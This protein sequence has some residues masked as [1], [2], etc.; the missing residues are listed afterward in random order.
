[1]A[2]AVEGE[3]ARVAVPGAKRPP[4]PRWRPYQIYVL[5]VLLLV[6]ASNYLDRA[7]VGILQQPIK[8]DLGLTDWQLGMISGPA[9]ALL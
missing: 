2:D 5:G 3:M 6:N 8:E 7:V 9:F 1:M 4:A